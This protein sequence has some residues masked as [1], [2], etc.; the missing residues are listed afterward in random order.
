MNSRDREPQQQLTDEEIALLDDPPLS[1]EEQVE[2][3]ARRRRRMQFQKAVGQIV[4]EDTEAVLRTLRYRVTRHYRRFLVLLR[5]QDHKE[6]DFLPSYMKQIDII[7][8]GNPVQG[9]VIS[10]GTPDGQTPSCAITRNGDIFSIQTE[11][12]TRIIKRFVGPD[13]S[14]AFFD[15]EGRWKSRII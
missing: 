3:E 10:P 2:E 6:I 4:A 5:A 7:D 1:P 14:Y 13:Y 15:I 11:N 9:I 8:G 12:T